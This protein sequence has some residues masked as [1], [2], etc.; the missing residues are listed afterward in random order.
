[1]DEILKQH[2]MILK[3]IDSM[4]FIPNPHKST[5]KLY[6]KELIKYYTKKENKNEK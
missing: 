3:N 1:M 4:E 6:V 2:R 5:Q